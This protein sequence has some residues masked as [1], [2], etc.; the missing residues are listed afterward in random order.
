MMCASTHAWGKARVRTS[1]DGGVTGVVFGDVLL[2]LADEVSADISGLG[3]DAS[4]DAA[5][6]G[7]GRSTETVAGNGLV[8][9]LPVITVHLHSRV[10]LGAIVQTRGLAE[11]RAKVSPFPQFSGL[12]DFFVK[13]KEDNIGSL[14]EALSGQALL[15][16][17][18]G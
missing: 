1:N 18:P 9:A 2:H 7:N 10:S 3:V 15:T 16:M 13:L 17:L 8:D 6:Q 12:D 14:R 11:G 5:E 4:A